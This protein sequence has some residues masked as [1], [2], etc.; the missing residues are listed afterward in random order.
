MLGTAPLDHRK[1][2]RV[3]TRP[4]R[5]TRQGRAARIRKQAAGVA[6]YQEQSI[7]GVN[8]SRPTDSRNALD[9]R[10][11][12]RHVATMTY[13]HLLLHRIDP[14]L[15]MARFYALSIEAT[16]FADHAVVRRWGR[17]GTQGRT[18]TQMHESAGA[19]IAAFSHLAS[20]KRRRGYDTVEDHTDHD[21]STSRTSDAHWLHAKR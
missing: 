8:Q 6:R 15:N 14:K 7:N 17:I 4:R 5:W 11:H 16:L 3:S 18:M 13:P 10:R 19:A 9:A 20:A 21:R 2:R 12:R 1:R